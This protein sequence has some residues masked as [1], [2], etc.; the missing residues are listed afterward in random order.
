MKIAVNDIK[1]LR[2]MRLPHRLGPAQSPRPFLG[3]AGAHLPASLYKP[4]I[5]EQRMVADQQSAERWDRLG[6]IAVGVDHFGIGEGR[7]KLI[8]ILDMPRV[9]EQPALIRIT[10]ANQPEH[11][12]KMRVAMR[13]ALL[14]PPQIIGSC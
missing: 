5:F 10:A 9:L 7:K 4:P 3:F 1:N 11:A 6:R 8:Q 14:L 13:L 2:R 12:L